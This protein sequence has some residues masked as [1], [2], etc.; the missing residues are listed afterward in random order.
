MNAHMKILIVDDE[1]TILKAQEMILSQNYSVISAQTGARA[2]EVCKEKKPD[3]VLLDIGLEDMDGFDVLTTIKKND[4]DVMVIMIT[5]HKKPEFIVKAV[6]MGAF[7]YLLKPVDADDLVLAVRNA[8]DNKALKNQIIAIQDSDKENIRSGFIGQNPEIK[9]VLKIAGKVAPSRNTPVLITGE[10]GAGKGVMAKF[11]H[12]NTSPLPGPFVI[13]NC[14]AIAKDLVETELF[15]YEPGCFTGANKEGKKGRFEA[16]FNGTLF[17]DEIGA[18]PISSQSKLLS[19]I[20]DREFYRV[21]GSKP[22]PLGARII[23][24]TN[25]NIKK[26]SENGLFRQDLFFRLNIISIEIPPLR[27]RQGDIILLAD[28]F[29]AKYASEFSRKFVGIS[30]RAKSILLQYGWPGNVR[31][32]K[33]IIERIVLLE[34]EP[35]LLP[36][37]LSFALGHD[38]KD[39]GNELGLVGLETQFREKSKK[40]IAKILKQTNGNITDAALFLDLPVHALRYKIKNL[41]VNNPMDK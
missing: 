3:L 34:D 26:N 24:A 28:Y 2:I 13:V 16:A 14:C 17:L 27:E 33:N 11:I 41:G 6:K 18:M 22:I 21:G 7:N 40:L 4:P 23:S 29:L 37:H 20:E 39:Q 10:S 9:K 19:V 12:Y 36:E 30:P 5:A 8:L 32:L 31:E 25:S 15:G 38:Q 1:K 35:L